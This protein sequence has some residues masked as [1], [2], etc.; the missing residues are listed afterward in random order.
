VI[1][2]ETKVNELAAILS[3][4]AKAGNLVS[5]VR[6][7]RFTGF[8]VG[9]SNASSFV[10]SVVVL[11]HP[12]PFLEAGVKAEK[13]GIVRSTARV[14]VVNDHNEATHGRRRFAQFRE[15]KAVLLEGV[16]FEGGE[17]VVKVEERRF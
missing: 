14:R 15:L 8:V 10:T 12:S 9:C 3:A 5:F 16:M 1:I 7:F 4:S 6:L 17:E 11:G 2:A 13:F